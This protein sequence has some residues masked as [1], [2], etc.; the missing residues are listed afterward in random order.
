[1]PEKGEN[2]EEHEEYAHTPSSSLRSCRTGTCPL[3]L[4]F[5]RASR[6]LGSGE[7]A[8]TAMKPRLRKCAFRRAS[9]PS[10]VRKGLSRRPFL[11]ERL[12][13]IRG[14]KR[15]IRG[16]FFFPKGFP[17]SAREKGRSAAVFLLRRAFFCEKIRIR[18]ILI[19]KQMGKARKFFGFLLTDARRS[20]IL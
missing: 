2:R 14:R 8:F 16:G 15:P 7:G 20:A 18:T 9:H 5:R 1:M 6:P 13:S 17:R 4:H 10:V 3:R 11:P 19:L 12:V